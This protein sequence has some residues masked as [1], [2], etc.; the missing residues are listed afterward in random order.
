[1]IGV[2]GYDL[3]EVFVGF[4]QIRNIAVGDE[5]TK[6]LTK[7]DACVVIRVCKPV[8]MFFADDGSK[9]AKADDCL[10]YEK[11]FEGTMPCNI[12]VKEW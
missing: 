6:F 7:E 3:K 12:Y 10:D 9:F 2:V 4:D 1:M 5:K 8:K 11:N